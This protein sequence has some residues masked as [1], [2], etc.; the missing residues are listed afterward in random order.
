M[1]D[2]RSR[3]P[4]CMSPASS[5]QVTVLSP[6][7]TAVPEAS[8][9]QEATLD[10]Q[11]NRHSTKGRQDKHF[12]SF[13]TEVLSLKEF[14]Q[15]LKS[16]CSASPVSPIPQSADRQSWGGLGF[17][18]QDSVHQG[19]VWVLTFSSCGLQT[20]LTGS[21]PSHDSHPGLGIT[22]SAFVKHYLQTRTPWLNL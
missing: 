5:L 15:P 10:P 4:A 19:A 22:E 21:C 13:R 8:G 11:R 12:L 17:F 1:W 9:T 20:F 18:A 14:A 6:F 2:P 7:I 3:S 16:A